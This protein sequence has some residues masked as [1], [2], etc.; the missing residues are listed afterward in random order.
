MVEFSC[1][2]LEKIVYV[3]SGKVIIHERR[4]M[5]TTGRVHIRSSH[6]IPKR[7]RKEYEKT[8]NGGDAHQG[9]TRR[10]R[11]D[12]PIYSAKSVWLAS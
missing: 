3:C 2:F 4:R 8:D 7:G 9:L 12:K 6:P 11:D 10:K 5:G 1:F